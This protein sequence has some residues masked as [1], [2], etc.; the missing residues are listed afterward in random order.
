[1][2][3]SGVERLV[4]ADLERRRREGERRGRLTDLL[5]RRQEHVSAT[6]CPQLPD[7]LTPDIRIRFVPHRH[8]P[9][10]EIGGVN[11]SRTHATIVPSEA[12]RINSLQGMDIQCG[13]RYDGAM[14][15]VL[16][17]TRFADE[18]RRWRRTRRW[19]QL[20]LAVRAG[21]T[22]RHLSFIEGGRSSPGRAIVLRLAESLS[23]TLRERNQLLLAAG[24]APAFPESSLDDPDLRPVHEAL[25][26]ILEGH[27]PYPAVVTR[28]YG[29]LVAANRAL[30]VI[31]DGAAPSLLKPTINVLRL[32]LHPDG[33]ARHVRNLPEWG[34]H[35]IDSL[36]A[37]ALRSPDDRLDAFI[38]ELKTYVP[39]VDPGPEH[40]G[41]A[42]P[43]RLHTDD[44]ELHLIS[45]LTSFS[46]ATDV[47]LAELHLE[48]FLPA[49]QATA[50]ILQ[51]RAAI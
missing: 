16:E 46:T 3:D 1:V 9:C 14:T 4:A 40:L 19:S 33:I 25:D 44:G 36:S 34:R 17:P 49:D 23:L 11:R 8:I 51:R 26:R 41:F 12:T 24:Y 15:V 37:Q 39:K 6:R 18:L 38:A 10:D 30:G 7:R 5:G 20:D 28:P 31:T 13:E 32:A 27:L 22:Q 29:E 45:T 21:T 2:C 35:I 42:V 43:L 48:A 47:T 50:T